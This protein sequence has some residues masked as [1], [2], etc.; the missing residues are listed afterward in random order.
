MGSSTLSDSQIRRPRPSDSV[1]LDKLGFKATYDLQLCILKELLA[2]VLT[3][4]FDLQGAGTSA[5]S[6]IVKYAVI[7]A[8]NMAILVTFIASLPLAVGVRNVW[9]RIGD[10]NSPKASKKLS[11]A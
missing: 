4:P 2:W 6:A 3:L 9:L 8:A 11:H 1:V 5:A 10:R 7:V